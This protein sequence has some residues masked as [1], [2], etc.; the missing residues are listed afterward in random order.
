MIPNIGCKISDSD[1]FNGRLKGVSDDK[2]CVLLP[3]HDCRF[4]TSYFERPQHI[5]GVAFSGRQGSHMRTNKD[6]A[7]L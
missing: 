1:G 5:T 3:T 2:V 4:T 7:G 6:Q